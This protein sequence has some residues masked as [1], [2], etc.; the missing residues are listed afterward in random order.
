M[1]SFVILIF[2][3]KHIIFLYFQNEA[4]QCVLFRVLRRT[5][6][7]LLNRSEKETSDIRP[8]YGE[9]TTLSPAGRHEVIASHT[10]KKS[11]L[12]MEKGSISMFN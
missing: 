4:C 1:F 7:T 10:V 3:L 8:T 6:S 9:I 12:A 5:G 11:C 2:V